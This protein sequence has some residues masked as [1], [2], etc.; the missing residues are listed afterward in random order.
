[1]RHCEVWGGQYRLTTLVGIAAERANGSHHRR[2]DTVMRK[3][4]WTGPKNLRFGAEQAKGYF[5]VAQ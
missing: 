1:M 5:K 4:G 2:L 3:L